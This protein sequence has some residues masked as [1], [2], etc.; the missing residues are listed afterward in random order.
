M[1]DLIATESQ[2]LY[3][4]TLITLYEIDT[5]LY[6]GSVIRFHSCSNETLSF[7]GND[8]FPYPITASGFEYNGRGQAPQP[9]LTASILDLAFSAQLLSANNLENCP[10]KRIKTY[11]KFLDDGSDPQPTATIVVDEFYVA[12]MSSK[13]KDHVS[14][15]LASKM[16]KRGRQIPGRQIIKGTCMFSYRVWNAESNQFNYINATCPYSGSNNFDING[17]ATTADKDVCSKDL[18][19]CKLRYGDSPLPF[20]GFPG[21]GRY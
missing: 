6:G 2:K 18:K 8:Y 15:T 1:S 5:A 13:T 4:D 16:D 20:G 9:T 3:H 12:R 11:R 10:V 14:L 21:A 19:G 17:N 7:N